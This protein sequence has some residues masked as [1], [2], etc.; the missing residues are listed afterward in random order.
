MTWLEDFTLFNFIYSQY[1]SARV[2]LVVDFT[3][4]VGVQAAQNYF[5]YVE[6]HYQE[7]KFE[8]DKYIKIRL[9]YLKC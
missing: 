1:Q 6:H 5:T 7:S 2:L 3:E 8:E 4:F 9:K